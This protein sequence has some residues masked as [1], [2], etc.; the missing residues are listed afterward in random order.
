MSRTCDKLVLKKK[1]HLRYVRRD[2]T[3][4]GSVQCSQ[5]LYI[6][7]AEGLYGILMDTDIAHGIVGEIRLLRCLY[8]LMQ[9]SMVL[10]VTLTLFAS[11]T[12]LMIENSTVLPNTKTVILSSNF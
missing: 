2:R 8:T 1:R 3:M 11:T 7:T 4:S 9:A 12:L 5:Q 6:H 10:A